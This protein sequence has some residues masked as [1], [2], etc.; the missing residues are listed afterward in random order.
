MRLMVQLL[1]L[2]VGG[3]GLGERSASRCQCDWRRV[4]DGDDVVGVPDEVDPGT[5]A[6]SWRRRMAV[7]LQG[8]QARAGVEVDD[9]SG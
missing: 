3:D 8:N 9:V 6:Q 7:L 4:G 1:V 5:A 2:R